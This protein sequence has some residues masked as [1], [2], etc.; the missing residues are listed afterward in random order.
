MLDAEEYLHLALHA[1]A[2]GDHH[3]C[4]TYLDNALQREPGNARAIYLRAAQHAELGLIERSI[5]GMKSALALDPMLEIARFQLG[6]LLLLNVNRPHEAKEHLAPVIGTANR[7]L[8]TFAEAMIALADGNTGLARERLSLGL[9]LGPGSGPLA[10]LMQR[11]LDG[12]KDASPTAKSRPNS[13]N[14]EIDLGA[15]KRSE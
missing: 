6:L 7:A 8:G 9:S 12:L 3:A 10:A 13:A 1:N 15:Y 14:G 4:L 2:A 5:V 11:V